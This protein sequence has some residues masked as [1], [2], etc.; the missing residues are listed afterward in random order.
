MCSFAQI[1]I[2]REL[3]SPNDLI[4]S[5][6]SADRIASVRMGALVSMS[7]ILAAVVVRVILQIVCSRRRAS[8]AEDEGNDGLDDGKSNTSKGS[9]KSSTLFAADEN[10]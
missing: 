3:G 2:Y 1:G 6:F 4:T 8:G 5:S 9:K 7:M 10:V